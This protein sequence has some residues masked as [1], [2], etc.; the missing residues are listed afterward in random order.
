[1]TRDEVSTQNLKVT[2]AMAS[3]TAI[4]DL[5]QHA[6]SERRVES[7]RDRSARVQLM[8]NTAMLRKTT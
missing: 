5:S 8:G 7:W 3:L 4:Q 6:D 1:M 2:A